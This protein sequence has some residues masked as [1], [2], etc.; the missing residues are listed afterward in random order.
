MFR[1]RVL[2][3]LCA[4]VLS[5]LLAA[6]GGSADEEPAAQPEPPAPASQDAPPSPAPAPA[7]APAP[8][9]TD[10][11]SR[12]VK[13][14]NQDTGGSGEYQFVP[15]KLQFKLNETVTFEMLA[16][17]EFHTFTVDALGIDE[18]ANGG[19]TLKFTHTFDKPGTFE[20]YCIVHK[21]YGM[22]GEIVVE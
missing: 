9:A 18:S 6:C 20:L 1:H 8:E 17:T 19:E 5:A 4:L 15:S 7:P 12:V 16:E 22:V 14:V 11:G 2:P 21:V 10:D 13:V 3:I